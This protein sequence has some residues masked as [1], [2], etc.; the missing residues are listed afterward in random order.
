MI[1]L[2]DLSKSWN[3]YTPYCFSIVESLLLQTPGGKIN[4]NSLI[5]V[6]SYSIIYHK[7]KYISR[8]LK[9]TYNKSEWTN[10]SKKEVP[11]PPQFAHN[12]GKRKINGKTTSN[13]V[14]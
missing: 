4:Q 13:I 3:H 5:V 8:E 9:L 7:S 12:E 2:R 10:R 14:G 1:K 6:L 11:F